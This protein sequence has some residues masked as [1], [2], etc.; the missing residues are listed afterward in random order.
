MFGRRVQCP[1]EVADREWIEES[2]SWLAGRFGVSLLTN[3]VILPTSEYFPEPFSGEQKQLHALVTGVAS[4]MG[5]AQSAQLTAVPL[6][7]GS[8]AGVER[9]LTGCVGYPGGAFRG[10]EG[11]GVIAL[12]PALMSRPIA[13]VATVAHMLGHL[14]FAGKR[15][16]P[17]RR[18]SREGLI[19]LLA[20]YS[21]FGI[22]SAN[23]AVQVEVDPRANERAALSYGLSTGRLTFHRCGYLTEQVHGYALACLAL[24]RG[25]TRPTWSRHLDTNP[26]VYMKQS[27]RY[28]AQHPSQRL[29]AIQ[30]GVTSGA[31]AHTPDVS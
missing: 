11:D 6:V 20:V 27:L 24:M 31:S 5:L 19:D 26:R 3:G 15:G 2:F 29:L 7:R 14:S 30:A 10:G 28:L 4:A 16:I 9:G 21:G 18:T 17:A 13:L 12:D 25:E 8:G 23:A 1:V 22:F